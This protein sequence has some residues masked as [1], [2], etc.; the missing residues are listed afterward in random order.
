M[1]GPKFTGAVAKYPARFAVGAYLALIAVGTGVLLLPA[2]RVP[3]VPRFTLLDALFTATSAVCVTGLTVRS[4][5][6]EFSWVGQAVLL[7]LIQLGGIGIITVTTL[8]TFFGEG[9]GGGGIRQQLAV[10]EALGSRPGD[11]VRWV[12]RTVV[13]AVLG[14]EAVGFGLL[15]TRNLEDY[16]PSTA[17]WHALFHSVSA[18][19]N[20]GFALHDDSLVRY[21][22]D[23]WVNLTIGGLIILGGIG[24]PVVLD[25]HRGVRQRGW[26]WYRDLALHTKL[27][28]LGTA[29]L[30]LLGTAAFLILESRNTLVGLSWPEQLLTAFFHSTTCRTAGFNTVSVS[31]LTNAMLFVSILLMMIGA[32]PCSCG[33]GIKV[34]TVMVLALLARDRLR[35]LENVR[36]ARRTISEGMIDRAVAVVLLYSL[37]LVLGLTVL[38][39]LEQSEHPHHASPNPFLDAMF[40][41]ASALGTVGLS[42]GL[43]TELGTT[44]RCILIGLMF[45]GRLGPISLFVAVSRTRRDVRLEY[46]KEDV[47]IG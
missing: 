30:L 33:G 46:A 28:L 47:L 20:A 5:G 22:A 37:A 25:V 42:T 1:A 6:Q 29:G 44:G 19:C 4:T 31:G 3:G 43:T 21:R 36:F 9:R 7:G 11:D 45:I 13:L 26:W 16:D 2:C 12:V 15:F 41:V 17:S 10:S 32:S 23:V 14:F 27:V 34:S 24:F 35:G 40:E 39:A 8:A 38:L 18:F